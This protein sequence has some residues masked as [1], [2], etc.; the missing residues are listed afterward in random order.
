MEEVPKGS[1]RHLVQVSLPPSQSRLRSL[2]WTQWPASLDI[3]SGS[4]VAMPVALQGTHGASK[5]PHRPL[6][7]VFKKTLDGQVHLNFR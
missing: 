1:R 4:L 7:E 3:T 6:W 2:A 5:G